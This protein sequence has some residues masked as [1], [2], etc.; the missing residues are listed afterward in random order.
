M[1]KQN[2]NNIKYSGGYK[3]SSIGGNGFGSKK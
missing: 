3:N 1:I 2:N